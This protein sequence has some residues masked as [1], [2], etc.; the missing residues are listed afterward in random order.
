MSRQASK[1]ARQSQAAI[2]RNEKGAQR[3]LVGPEPGKRARKASE[4]L[5]AAALATVKAAAAQPPRAG[6][7]GCWRRVPQVARSGPWPHC[8]VGIA[9]EAAPTHVWSFSNDDIV[10]GDSVGDAI[11]APRGRKHRARKGQARSEFPRREKHTNLAIAI[12]VN[13]VPDV[14]V[15]L[16]V[17][18]LAALSRLQCMWKD[19][20]ARKVPQ[21][22]TYT[23][24]V[25][26]AH[27]GG[28]HQSTI[29]GV[30]PCFH[31]AFTH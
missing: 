6:V 3:L 29:L 25:V 31:A 18:I 24:H 22:S 7:H 4:S 17:C 19:P 14:P 1:P 11:Y 10:A 27:S 13:P 15:H 30:N 21:H 26:D 9:D 16:L 8:R 20:V 2:L 28:E 12:S 23:M 5:A